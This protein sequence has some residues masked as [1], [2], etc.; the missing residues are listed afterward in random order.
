MLRK[1]FVRCEAVWNKSEM[2]KRL[3]SFKD[4]NSL[5]KIQPN[6]EKRVEE[7]CWKFLFLWVR[8]DSDTY[9]L[10]LCSFDILP[11]QTTTTEMQQEHRTIVF[12]IK[13]PRFLGLIQ[14]FFFYLK[15]PVFHLHSVLKTLIHE[16]YDDL[17]VGD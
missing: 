12:S 15:L 6:I 4:N 2:K 13:Q 8:S 16:K 7:F 9:R 10:S 17:M 1:W 14:L 11:N 3:M 5:K